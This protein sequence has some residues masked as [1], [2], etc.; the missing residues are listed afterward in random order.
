M[1]IAWRYKHLRKLDDDGMNPFGT[2]SPGRVLRSSEV[3]SYDLG[4]RISEDAL[5]TTY[6]ELIKYINL[7]DHSK[8]INDLSEMI[9]NSALE[10]I[11]KAQ[12][13]GSVVR[14]ILRTFPSPLLLVPQSS[15]ENS[16]AQLLYR[17]R[18]ALAP[19]ADRHLLI[20]S[21]P[22][23]VL[24]PP[25]S[26][27]EDQADAII[28]L[29]SFVGT[30]KEQVR[31]L[32]EYAGFLRIIKPLRKAGTLALQLPPS[33]DLA[34]KVRRRQLIFEPFHMPPDLGVEAASGEGDQGSLRKRGS[35]GSSL[36]CPTTG[37]DPNNL[38][39]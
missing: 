26:G 35:G 37:L 9:V 27:V 10:L 32:S 12:G 5:R 34:F 2:I 19:H 17:L 38:E 29:Q 7:M 20:V 25:A 30:P 3:R 23:P 24:F 8:T 4:K 11:G 18:R 28:E 33:S 1:T 22:S 31:S 14:I 16:S 6:G 21:S 36:S 15:W 13:K 39:F